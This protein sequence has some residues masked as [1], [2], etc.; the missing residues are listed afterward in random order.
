MVHYMVQFTV[1]YMMHYIVHDTVHS[2]VH[3]LREGRV[4][5]LLVPVF[6]VAHEVGH[7]VLV[8]KVSIM[9]VVSRVSTVSSRSTTTS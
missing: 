8:R 5:V 1:H 9:C 3:C 6:A 7:H 2:M 4:V